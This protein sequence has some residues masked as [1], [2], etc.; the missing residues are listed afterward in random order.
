MKKRK[1]VPPTPFY[2]SR[3]AEL[4]RREAQRALESGERTKAS[5]LLNKAREY[6]ILAGEFDMEGQDEQLH[7]A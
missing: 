5:E 6:A 3:R 7:H 2:L 1:P 4:F